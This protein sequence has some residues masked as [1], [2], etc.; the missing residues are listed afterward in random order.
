MIGSCYVADSSIPVL[1]YTRER[2]KS[3][4]LVINHLHLV[5]GLLLQQ[6]VVGLHPDEGDQYDAAPGHSNIKQHLP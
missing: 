1:K 4:V 5:D 2:M 6:S 3:H